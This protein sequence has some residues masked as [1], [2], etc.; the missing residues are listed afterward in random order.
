MKCK[1]T[2]IP[3]KLTPKV[4]EEIDELVKLGVFASR[5]EAIKFGIRLMILIEK[6][7]LPISKRAE[8]YACQEIKD[9]FERI[10]NVC[11]G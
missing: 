7:D 1:Q 2:A 11:R 5:S 8:E 10:K 6:I 3:V 9:K 4:I